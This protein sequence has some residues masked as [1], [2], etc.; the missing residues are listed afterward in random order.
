MQ[1]SNTLYWVEVQESDSIWR[2]VPHTDNGKNQQDKP[3]KFFDRK[4]AINFRDELKEAN[5]EYWFRVVKYTETY[6][7]DKSFIK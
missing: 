3:Y 4:E 1:H 6:K 2:K 7:Y 5:P